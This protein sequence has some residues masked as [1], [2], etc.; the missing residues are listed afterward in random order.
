MNKEGKLLSKSK[1]EVKC[2]MSDIGQSKVWFTLKLSDFLS[3]NQIY[4]TISGAG[5]TNNYFRIYESAPKKNSKDGCVFKEFRINISQINSENSSLKFEFYE[6]RKDNIPR[7][8]GTLNI[9]LLSLISNR[10]STIEIF[11]NFLVVGKM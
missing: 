11:K 1:L 7:L 9:S 2:T 10:D 4:F 6:K 3:K 5:I 8:L